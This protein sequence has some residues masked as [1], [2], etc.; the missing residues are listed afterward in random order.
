[1]TILSIVDYADVVLTN[2]GTRLKVN[3]YANTTGVVAESAVLFN[4]LLRFNFWATYELRITRNE[5]I[6]NVDGRF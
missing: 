3:L 1:M 5:A 4:S 6:L 2:G